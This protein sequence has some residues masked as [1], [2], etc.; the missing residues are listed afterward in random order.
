[1]SLTEKL[2]NSLYWQYSRVM[3]SPYSSVYAPSKN[4]E[5]LKC[6]AKGIPVLTKSTLKGYTLKGS[7][8]IKYITIDDDE[9]TTQETVILRKGKRELTRFTNNFTAYRCSIMTCVALKE[10]CKL[11]GI[12]P[13]NLSVG[14]IGTGV[15]NQL[16]MK[17]INDVYG[18]A[19]CV[20]RGSKRNRSKNLHKFPNVVVSVD[21]D[22]T[23]LNECDIIISCTSDCTGEEMVGTSLLTKPKVF[24]ALDTG[25]IL[26]ES[27]RK[28][29][30]SYTDHVNQLYG[31]YTEEFPFDK[32]RYPM[33]QLC[34]DKVLDKGRLAVYLYG[35]GFADAVVAEGLFRFSEN[36]A[37]CLISEMVV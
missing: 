4:V 31:H 28:N 17:A 13:Y 35:T 25:F 29:C 30:D 22:Y 19:R 14:F 27:F 5:V 23:K 8:T 1:M 18:I 24:I 34:K 7:N 32:G 20:I 2:V 11:M 37:K 16:N 21:T 26:D 36:L 33:K 3:S 10:S 12:S 9:G 6:N 15:T